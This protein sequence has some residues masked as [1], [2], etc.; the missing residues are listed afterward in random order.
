MATT[1]DTQMGNE[2]PLDRAARL[3][4]GREI[5]AQRRDVSVA[6]IGNWKLRGVPLEHCIPIEQDTARAVLC[7]EL[8]PDVDWAYLRGTAPQPTE[9][10]AAGAN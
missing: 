6:A 4:G 5:L 2:H 7:E 9:P 3:L 1:K 8:R 10:A